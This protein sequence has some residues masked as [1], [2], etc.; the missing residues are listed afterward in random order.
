VGLSRLWR[1]V[2]ARARFRRE[3]REF[4][5]R[6][7]AG[8]PRFALDWADRWPCLK[9]RTPKA[10]FDRH[11]VFHT[12]WAARVLARTRPER[13]VD[14]GSSLFFAGIASA[15]VRVEAYDL[16]PAAL[17]LQGLKTGAADLLALPFA[18]GSVPSLSCMHVVE[19]VGL[20]RYGDPIDPEGD[21][22][23]VAEIRRVLAPGGSLLFVVP[24]GKARIQFN[25]HRVYAYRQVVD[26]FR[27]LDLVEFALIPDREEDG[28]LVVGA[29]EAL[30]D[31]QSYGCG[32]WWFR[33]PR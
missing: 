21:R 20:G 26:A 29:S 3:F 13:H 14:L 5:A 33:R 30:A 27:G 1:G 6:S 11:Y 15:F 17:D 22:K 16:R 23:A 19:H 12:A 24:T 8:E 25:A 28:G 9:D 32:C 7:A 4:S 10:K 18:D 2:R 31:R